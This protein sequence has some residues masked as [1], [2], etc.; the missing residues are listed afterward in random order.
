LDIISWYRYGDPTKPQ[1]DLRFLLFFLDDFFKRNEIEYWIDFGVLLGC[2]RHGEMIPWDYDLDFGLTPES[3]EKFLRAAAICQFPDDFRL[4]VRTGYTAIRY[5]EVWADVV[6]YQSTDISKKSFR[7]HVGDAECNDPE[8]RENY[9][10]S[11]PQE[12]LFPLGVRYTILFY[13]LTFSRKPKCFQEN[14]M[15]P[16]IQMVS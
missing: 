13:L 10:P 1:K 8:D 9:L 14:S 15:F 11:I 5:N 12:F 2:I 4:D 3:Y 6:L 7:P 16:T